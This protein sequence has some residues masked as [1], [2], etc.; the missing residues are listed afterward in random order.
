MIKQAVYYRKS[1]TKIKLEQQMCT[2]LSEKC[3]RNKTFLT[4][5]GYIFTGPDLNE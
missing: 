5:T 4:V 3:G 1:D 2:C